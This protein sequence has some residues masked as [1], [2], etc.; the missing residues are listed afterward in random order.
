MA[1]LNLSPPTIETGEAAHLAA[2][3]FADKQKWG[4]A[5][6]AGVRE[7][8]PEFLD[9][10]FP[11]ASA[12]GVGAYG[13]TTPVAQ[14]PVAGAV[15]GVRTAVEA[16]TGRAISGLLPQDAGVDWG[17][18]ASML[19]K[20]GGAALAGGVDNIQFAKAVSHLAGQVLSSI[21]VL[22]TLAS[23]V[24]DAIWAGI[25]VSDAQA[26]KACEAFNENFVTNWKSNCAALAKR[27]VPIPTDAGTKHGIEGAD[28]EARLNPGDTF[29]GLAYAY[30]K[31]SQRIPASPASIYLLL[32]GPES[33]GFGFSRSEYSRLRKSVGSAGGS[34]VPASTQRRMW[35]LVKGLM[36]SA[37]PPIG[38]GFDVHTDGGRLLMPILQELVRTS[39]AAGQWNQRWLVELNRVIGERWS[40]SDH[41]HYDCPWTSAVRR[42][43]IDARAD[44]AGYLDI[45]TTCSCSGKSYSQ[46]TKYPSTGTAFFDLVP[47]FMR[48]ITDWKVRL[49]TFYNQKT[50]A[51]DVGPP[52]KVQAS[53]SLIAKTGLVVLNKKQ[54]ASLVNAVGSAMEASN[55]GVDPIVA[56]RRE[57]D[58]KAQIATT[59][60]VLAGGA[61][62][63]ARRA[64]RKRA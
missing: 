40:F 3:G 57:R 56:A 44:C 24:L 11:T 60:V 47:G 58:R 33:Q 26:Q 39:F 61:F 8:V 49:G 31:G 42:V 5:T 51:W 64:A 37:R 4:D 2:S 13:G 55:D 32:C 7:L 14:L 50:Q 27:G 48:S 29:R 45:P 30:R 41:S 19:G 9:Q 54:A 43:P 22:A 38:G 16:A 17:S 35:L 28:F 36:A 10:V 21:P 63:L 20:L 15:A 18:V 52:P 34:G 23:A 53:L 25:E 46:N 62:V 59:G 1:K 6:V 12:G